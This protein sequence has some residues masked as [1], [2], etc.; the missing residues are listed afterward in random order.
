MTGVEDSDGI[1]YMLKEA[2]S[3]VPDSILS[4]MYQTIE[5]FVFKNGEWRPEPDGSIKNIKEWE[6]EYDESFDK[7]YLNYI[8]KKA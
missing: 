8:F 3:R 4:A 2:D 6:R 1:Q 5:D 7:S